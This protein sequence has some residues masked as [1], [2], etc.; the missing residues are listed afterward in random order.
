MPKRK[1]GSKRVRKGDYVRST[2]GF[3]GWVSRVGES[4][5]PGSGGPSGVLE[6]TVRGPMGERKFHPKELRVTPRTDGVPG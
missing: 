2:D 1:K 6:A 3:V 4:I 5:D